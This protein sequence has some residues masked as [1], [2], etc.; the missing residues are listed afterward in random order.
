MILLVF[1][2]G[3]A[4]GIAISDQCRATIAE[5]SK[6]FPAGLKCSFDFDSTQFVR[7]G[8]KDVVGRFP[9]VVMW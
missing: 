3:N 9:S 8:I 2:R 4:N 7:A 1:Q 5:L 6:G